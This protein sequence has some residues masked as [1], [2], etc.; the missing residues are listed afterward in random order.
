LNF[1]FFRSCC[2]MHKYVQ[3]FDLQTDAYERSRPSYPKE[4]VDYAVSQL[5]LNSSSKILDLAA[6]TGKFTRLLTENPNCQFE[7]V[8]VEPTEGMRRKFSSLLPNVKIYNGEA[9]NLPFEDNYFDA[10]F[11]AQSFHWFANE[12]ALKEIHRVLKV[13]AGF[14]MIWNLE[15]RSV[16]WIAKLRDAYEQYEGDTPQYRLGL[17]KSPWNTNLAKELFES[18]SFKQFKSSTLSTPLSIWE[19]VLSKSYISVLNEEEQKRFKE[20]VFEILHHYVEEF[21]CLE[22]LPQANVAIVY[23]YDTDLFITFKK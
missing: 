23:P 6:G 9:E 16:E 5:K 1:C 15:D 22:N 7:V 11:A 8:A 17:W 10:V 4:A 19:R 13:G 3:A 21:K 18:L 20:K 2:E 12:K 14:V